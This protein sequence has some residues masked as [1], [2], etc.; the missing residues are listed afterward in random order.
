[1]LLFEILFDKLIITEWDGMSGN[2]IGILM[3]SKG[4]F[5]HFSR[6]SGVFK[7]KRK[8]QFIFLEFE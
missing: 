7:G 1:M 4:K 3:Q 8:K 2:D 6:K 5:W